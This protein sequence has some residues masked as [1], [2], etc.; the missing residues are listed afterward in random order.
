M[1][2]SLYENL[3]LRKEYLTTC[4]HEFSKYE[5]ELLEIKNII[6]LKESTLLNNSKYDFI[7]ELY[8]NFLEIHIIDSQLKLYK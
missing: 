3:C 5:Q 7:I 1:T 4:L 2:S 6:A 8:F